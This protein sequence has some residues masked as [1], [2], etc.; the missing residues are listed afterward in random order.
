MDAPADTRE[1]PPRWRLDDLYAGRDD[2]GI[3]A[4]LAAAGALTDDLASLEGAFLA[5]R[6]EPARLGALIDRAIRLCEEAIDKAWG[7][8]AFASL[9]GTVDHGDPGWA[10]LEADIR[11]RL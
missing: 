7:V 6:T 10:R 11:A 9:S 4:D 8:A 5:A 3:E 2:P 1:T